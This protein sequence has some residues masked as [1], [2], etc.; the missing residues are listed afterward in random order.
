M[1][2][3]KIAVADSATLPGGMTYREIAV[4]LGISPMRV[5]QI[6]QRALGK[7]RKAFW[8]QGINGCFGNEDPH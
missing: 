6:E 2:A 8:R 4:H 1:K 7:L 3:L 5:C